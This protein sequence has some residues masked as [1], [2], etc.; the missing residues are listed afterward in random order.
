F[1][2]YG[3]RSGSGSYL[4]LATV[5][6]CAEGRC[7]Y[8][9]LNVASGQGYDYYVATVDQRTDRETPSESAVQVDVPRMAPPAAPRPDTVV[10]LDNA[11]YL[12]WLP[13]ADAA[14][15]AIWKYQVYLVEL[16]DN[17]AQ[18]VLY[19]VGGTDATGFLDLRATNGV[20]YSYRIA[21]VDFDGHISEMSPLLRGVPRPDYTAEVIYAF[22]DRAERSGFRFVASDDLDPI[23]PGTSAEA[24][25][26]LEI[27][28]GEWMVRP[29]NGAEIHPTGVFTTA[30]TCGPRSDADCVSV[31]QAPA[32]GYGTNPVPVFSEYT[33]LLR[34]PGANA[35]R[36]AKLRVTLRGSD[37]NG[38]LIVFDWAYQTR[39]GVRSLSMME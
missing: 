24:H 34:V 17:S 11:L 19:Q 35:P 23:V 37:Q 18:S 39:P 36:Y 32:G 13:P 22:A 7:R 2:V 8:T 15:D 31:D 21:A 5:T 20:E 33:Y 9:D 14:D 16:N 29:L 30:L 6:S 38:R 26:R 28:D 4:L 1:R 25:W 10:A 12:R 27:A 3:R